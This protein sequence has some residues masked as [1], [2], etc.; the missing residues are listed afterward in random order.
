MKQQD[1]NIC[2]FKITFLVPSNFS[3]SKKQL[4]YFQLCTVKYQVQES[5]PDSS[6]PGEVGWNM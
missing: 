6:K 3:T 5:R 1:F 2:L 4:T